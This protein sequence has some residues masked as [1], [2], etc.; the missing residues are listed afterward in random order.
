[1][2]CNGTNHVASTKDVVVQGTVQPSMPYTWPRTF[3]GRAAFRAPPHEDHRSPTK[4]CIC[5]SYHQSDLVRLLAEQDCLSVIK[6]PTR[7]IYRTVSD[8]IAPL[9]QACLISLLCEKRKTTAVLV[10]EQ[11]G[12][13]DEAT[14]S[15]KHTLASH[16]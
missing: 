12:T 1:M 2:Q 5:F 14:M 15:K 9:L 16:L 7:L 3:A 4:S 8:D 6:E 10:R 11:K 13:I